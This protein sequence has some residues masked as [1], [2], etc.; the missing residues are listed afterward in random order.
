MADSEGVRIPEN[1]LYYTEGLACMSRFKE[2]QDF[3]IF[4]NYMKKLKKLIKKE[5]GSKLIKNINAPIKLRCIKIIV[6]L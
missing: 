4:Q 2:K 6:N 5:I 3:P 1:T